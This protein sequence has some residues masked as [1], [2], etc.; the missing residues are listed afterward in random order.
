[1]AHGDRLVIVALEG[2]SGPAAH[3]DPKLGMCSEF[4]ECLHQANPIAFG[5][6][7]AAER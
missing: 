1:M 3:I 2:F 7:H 5:N 6:N 4:G